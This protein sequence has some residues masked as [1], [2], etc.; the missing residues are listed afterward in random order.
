M[1][2]YIYHFSQGSADGT[3]SMKSLLGAKGA[4]LAEM[5]RLGL[6]VPPGMTVSTEACRY[7]LERGG[8]PPGLL[9]DVQKGI[10]RLEYITGRGWGDRTSPLLVSVRSGGAE[11]MPGMMD[12]VLN[13]GLNEDTVEG[14]IEQSGDEIFALDCWRRMIQMYGVVVFGLDEELLQ[15]PIDAAIARAE[16]SVAQDLS[17]GQWRAVI[18]EMRLSIVEEVGVGIPRD[19]TE[20]LWAAVGA[21]FESWNSPR[22]AAYRR[23]HH[24]GGGVG[25]AV[26]IMT[27]V[28]GNLDQK[29]ASGVAFTRNPVTGA[30]Q[31]YGEYLPCAQGE[32]V[33]S[34]N[35]TP[36]LLSAVEERMPAVYAELGSYFKRL[37]GHYRDMLELEFTVESGRLWILQVRKGMRTGQAAVRIAL[38]MLD[39]E[40]I[41]LD[42]AVMRVDPDR[43]VPDLLSP[44]ID[45]SVERPVA[46]VHGLAASPGAAVG[47][48]VTGTA[49]AITRSRRG[50][51]VI[52]VRPRTSTGDIDGVS[53]AKA[54]LTTTGGLT[55]HAASVARGLGIPCVCGAQE[56]RIAPD[57]S[58]IFIGDNFI[59]RG[60]PLTVDGSSGSVYL[61]TLPLIEGGEDER[62]QRF[63]EICDRQRRM[64]IRVNANDLDG[65]RRGS[66]LG[67]EGIGLCR[68]EQMLLSDSGRL[69]A[70]RRAILVGEEG[71]AAGA[72]EDLLRFHRHDVAQILRTMMGWPVTFRLLDPPLSRFLPHDEVSINQTAAALEMEPEDVASRVESLKEANPMM[73]LRGC[74]LGVVHPS[75]Y[76]M[77]VQAIV[78]ASRMV[79]DD[80]IRPI[81]EILIPL[82]ADVEELRRVVDQINQTIAEHLHGAHDSMSIELGAMIEIPRAALQAEEI[83]ECVDFL[84]FGTNDLT[85]LSWGMSG[86]DSRRFMSTYLDEQILS[87]DPFET[88]DRTGVGELMRIAIQRGR[89]AN[90]ELFVGV[91][92]DHARESGSARFFESLDID[93]LTVEPSDVPM[94]RVAAARAFVAYERA[95]AA[96]RMQ[97]E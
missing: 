24:I 46:V 14:L 16:V 40:L 9:V 71:E 31:P 61:D 69:M 26:N 25:T 81:V 87:H 43:H 77:Q 88:L 4:G 29:S 95:L 89:R 39:E 22:A 11:S 15:V 75:I 56:L 21:V 90:P 23:L 20:Q 10:E 30:P 34:G 27:M 78:E 41:D 86:E 67:A 33:V 54:V 35:R 52:L 80:G 57:G 42:E 44:I 7:Y 64:E 3:A 32:D 28:F 83:A 18:D 79:I 5:A 12:S 19:P 6:S 51:S 65:A 45:P 47:R 96:A 60:E 2:E 97:A 59:A 50:E 62:L 48:L 94:A 37:E 55:S 13:V 73:G 38:D 8:L 66:A 58:G 49:E 84:C 1:N 36:R 70:M 74:R 68:T 91:C 72:L 76:A 92:G 93:Y 63:L 53:A 82:V 85:Q 17:A